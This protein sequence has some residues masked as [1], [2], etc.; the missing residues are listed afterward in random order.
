MAMIA[1]DGGPKG[2]A[3]LAFPAHLATMGHWSMAIWEKW[4]PLRHLGKAVV[5]AKVALIKAV[6]SCQVLYGPAAAFLATA[7]RWSGRC[8][9]QWFA[10]RMLAGS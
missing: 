3:D 9:T 4:L 7:R 10:L 6:V 2:L 5:A 8:K 1:A